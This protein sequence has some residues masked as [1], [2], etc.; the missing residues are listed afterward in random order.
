M[1]KNEEDK[2]KTVAFVSNETL[3]EEWEFETFKIS[4]HDIDYYFYP[5]RQKRN[6]W[7]T[8]SEFQ[9]MNNASK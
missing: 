7:E 8:T 1:L 5:P 2:W 6:F 4:K 3:Q 9:Q